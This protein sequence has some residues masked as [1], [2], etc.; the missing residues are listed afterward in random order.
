MKRPKSVSFTGTHR[1]PLTRPMQNRQRSDDP[2]HTNRWTKASA[3]FRAAHPICE[4]CKQKGLI[5]PSEV[6]DHII[7]WPVCGDFWDQTNWQAL[8]RKCNQNK[9]NR[10]K[11]LIEKWRKQ[12]S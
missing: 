1:R 6:T 11:K 12:Q 9:G 3:A 4:S 2:Y 5:V 7:P 10:D 8:C